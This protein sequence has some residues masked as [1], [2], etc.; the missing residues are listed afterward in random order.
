M[1]ISFTHGYSSPFFPS[2]GHWL[3]ARHWSH[4]AFMSRRLA[5]WPMDASRT[6]WLFSDAIFPCFGKDLKGT[7]QT[8]VSPRVTWNP[9]SLEVTFHHL[10]GHLTTPKRSQRI[11]SNMSLCFFSTESYSQFTMKV[12][13][14]KCH[15]CFPNSYHH[16]QTW[17][18]QIDRMESMARMA[19][20]H[21]SDVLFFGLDGFLLLLY[22]TKPIKFSTKNKIVSEL[23]VV[24]F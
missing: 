9:R 15:V 16:R 23:W 2:D 22:Q 8:N 6:R 5:K 11:A 1:F 19:N 4:K 12:H 18:H 21:L 14:V 17:I 3:F 7:K 10:K 20:E 13:F 24:S